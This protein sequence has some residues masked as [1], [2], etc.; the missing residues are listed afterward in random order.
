MATQIRHQSSEAAPIEAE[1]GRGA[2]VDDRTVSLGV[3]TERVWRELTKASFAYIG[4]VTPRGEPRTSGVGYKARDGRLY[5][6]TAPGS[7][8]AKHIAANGRVSMT[9][10][11][12]RGGLL[13]LVVPIPPATI[14]FHGS[15][16]VYPFGSTKAR[17]LIEELGSLVP[18]ARRASASIIEVIPEGTF[19]TYGVGVSLKKMLDPNAAGG[20]VAVG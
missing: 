6:A 9:V 11:V 16:T 3:T 15:A 1:A 13:S 20:R 4:C 7:W 10:P 12:R 5:L 17:A 19:L 8:K 18:P 2:S 14:T